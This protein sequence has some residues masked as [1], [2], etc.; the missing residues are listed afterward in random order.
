LACAEGEVGCGEDCAKERP[1]EIVLAILTASKTNRPATIR[2]FKN[3]QLAATLLVSID[4]IVLMLP[5]ECM[6]IHP[7]CYRSDKRSMSLTCDARSR[8]SALFPAKTAAHVFFAR[9]LGCFPISSV[10][11]S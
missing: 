1:S 11:A 3:I 10:A 9:S 7:L 5:V 4:E 2:F 8:Y 6:N